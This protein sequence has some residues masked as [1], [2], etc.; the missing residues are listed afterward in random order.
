MIQILNNKQVEFVTTAIR[1]ILNIP[2]SLDSFSLHFC[3]DG[4]LLFE[5]N[6]HPSKR[7]EVMV[8]APAYDEDEIDYDAAVKDT[9]IPPFERGFHD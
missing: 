3:R 1:S 5:N 4:N 8:T 9:T 6:D 7:G 2:D